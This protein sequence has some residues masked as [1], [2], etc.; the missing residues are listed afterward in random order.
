MKIEHEFTVERPIGDV[1]EFFQDVPA[2]AD[3]LPGAEL[4][5]DKGGNVYAGVVSVKLG[6]MTAAFEG[7]ATIT[8]DAEAHS[9]TISGKGVDKR[10]GSRGQVTVDYALTEAE[11][12]AT[13]VGIDADVMLS[14]PAAQ[15][16]RTGLINE[17]S[18]RLISEFVECL[19]GKLAATTRE[20][21]AE[22]RADSQV[23]GFAL[24][25][26]SLWAW[27]KRRFSSAG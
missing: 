10:G 4:R 24:F 20:A 9:A 15:F 12:G 11:A 7:E 26:S 6:P 19:E 5:E 13:R 18:K 3:C 27:I 21:A 14:G 17:I 16:G 22:V 2:V 8:P 23:N 25:F 1:W